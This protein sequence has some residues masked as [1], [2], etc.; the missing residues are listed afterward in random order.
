MLG[1]NIFIAVLE[2][3]WEKSGSLSITAKQ[4]KYMLKTSCRRG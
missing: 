2:K 1:V 4:K 3:Q